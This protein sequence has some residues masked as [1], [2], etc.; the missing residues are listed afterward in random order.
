MNRKGTKYLGIVKKTVNTMAGVDIKIKTKMS[1]D[2]N[3]IEIWINNYTDYQKIIIEYDEKQ[4]TDIENF[5]EDFEDLAPLT[6]EDQK[7]AE[8][9]YKK[10]MSKEE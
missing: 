4:A 2:K 9:A 7:N 1:T 3:E 8:A 6:E 5:F 10:L